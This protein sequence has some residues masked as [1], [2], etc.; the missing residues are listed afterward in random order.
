MTVWSWLLCLSRLVSFRPDMI[1]YVTF[2][3]VPAGVDWE[4]CPFGTMAW[5]SAAIM[6]SIR[7]FE[8]SLL[9]VDRGVR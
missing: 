1:T 8:R 9:N 7:F 6:F 2:T 3:Y 4:K 5:I